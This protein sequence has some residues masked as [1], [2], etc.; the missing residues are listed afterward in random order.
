MLQWSERTDRWGGTI[1]VAK[2]G[3]SQVATADWVPNRTCRL[4]AIWVSKRDYYGKT[5]TKEAFKAQIQSEWEAWLKRTSL[6]AIGS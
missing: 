2:H 4:R 1:L 3:L 6:S 5:F